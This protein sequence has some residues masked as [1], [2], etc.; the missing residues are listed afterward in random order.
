MENSNKCNGWTNYATWRVNLECLSE[1]WE[2]NDD[3][4]E[5][6]DGEPVKVGEL[7][8]ILAVRRGKTTSPMH[9]EHHLREGDV[10]TVAI[11]T[12]DFD[13]ATAALRAMGFTRRPEREP[14]EDA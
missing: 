4:V 13:E 12:P 8:V 1:Y 14:G 2:F 9:S 6:P 11:H 5:T 10:V 3:A 7:F